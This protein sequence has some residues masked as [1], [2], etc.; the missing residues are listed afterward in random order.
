MTARL[1]LPGFWGIQSGSDKETIELRA[2][3]SRT[4]PKIN[5]EPENN[6]LEDDFPLP[7]VY[8]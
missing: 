2:I 3:S 7:V 4:P 6:G 5:T 8:M 1:Y